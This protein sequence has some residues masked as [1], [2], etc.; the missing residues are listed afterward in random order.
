MPNGYAL[1]IFMSCTSF[2]ASDV[3]NICRATYVRQINF[4]GTKFQVVIAVT[5]IN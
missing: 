4:S 3:R 1:Q 2:Q 5:F